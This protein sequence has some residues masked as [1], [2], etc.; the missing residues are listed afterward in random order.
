[1]IEVLQSAWESTPWPI[2]VFLDYVILRGVIFYPLAAVIRS[3]IGKRLVRTQRD[4]IIWTHNFE[5]ARKHGHAA[6]T[7]VECT[8]GKCVSI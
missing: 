3:L 7:A 2:R 1:M 4:L 6:K 8:E 5:R